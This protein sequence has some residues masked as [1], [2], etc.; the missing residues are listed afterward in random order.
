MGHESR[1]RNF[2]W[3]LSSRTK[4]ALKD[5]SPAFSPLPG[6]LC[7]YD[8]NCELVLANQFCTNVQ[9]NRRC[10]D[11]M[12]SCFCFFCWACHPAQQSPP[13][14]S[15]QMS[16]LLNYVFFYVE[17]R[18]IGVYLASW[19]TWSVIG[20]CFWSMPVARIPRLS[21]LYTLAIS[22]APLTKPKW[23]ESKA[24]ISLIISFPTP[25]VS[26]MA[27]QDQNDDWI[28]IA[29]DLPYHCMS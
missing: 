17:Q 10:S 22:W 11:T 25:P 9:A 15:S 14:T 13:R 27:H 2:L 23:L 5:I 4:T 21:V 28:K 26:V 18:S 1:K 7:T 29:T 19:N 3:E 12:D 8:L 20:S 6:E 16:I 24:K